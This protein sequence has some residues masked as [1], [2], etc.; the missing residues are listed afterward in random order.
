MCPKMYFNSIKRGPLSYKGTVYITKTEMITNF[1]R[2]VE[3][4]SRKSNQISPS[5][6]VY[7]F[8][9]VYMCVFVSSGAIYL[10]TEAVGHLPIGG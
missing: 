5:L 4:T 1:I 6:T 10:N 9:L 2:Q 3:S 8:V 7:I